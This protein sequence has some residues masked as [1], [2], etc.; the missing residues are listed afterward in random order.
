MSRSQNSSDVPWHWGFLTDCISAED[1]ILYTFL[2]LP[3]WMSPPLYFCQPWTL[4]ILV[5]YV[6]SFLVSSSFLWTNLWL[7]WHIQKISLR[8]PP[9]IRV[10]FFWSSPFSS[11]SIWCADVIFLSVAF[12]V[13]EKMEL[14]EGDSQETL[15]SLLKCM[16][17]YGLHFILQWCL[18]VYWCIC[19]EIIN[20]RKFK[21]A[22]F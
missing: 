6:Q 20:A 17:I 16:F 12:L 14:L 19:N 4:N 9:L 11:Q 15:F 10:F 7:T 13:G 18:L 8:W 2:V 22:S 3:L 1:F 5:T 21:I